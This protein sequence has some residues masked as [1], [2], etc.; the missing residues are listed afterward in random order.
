MKVTIECCEG[1][2]VNPKSGETRPNVCL[3]FDALEGN[4]GCLLNF[5]GVTQPQFGRVLPDFVN[6]TFTYKAPPEQPPGGMDNF[7]YSG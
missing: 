2:E 1:L 4:K 6:N 7:T 3:V 5:D